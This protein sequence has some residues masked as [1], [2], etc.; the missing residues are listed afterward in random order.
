MKVINVKF[1]PG[2]A[3]LLFA[4][5]FGAVRINGLSLEDLVD[6]VQAA[7]LKKGEKS[8]RIQFGSPK[9]ILAPRHEAV[10][11]L[12]ENTRSKLGPGIMAETLQLYAKPDGAALWTASQQTAFF[13]AVAAL[14]SLEGLQYYSAS[15]SA[16]RTLYETSTVID[17]PSTK[18]AVPDPVYSYLPGEL[19]LYARQKDLT[20]GD[21]IYQ[22]DYRTSSDSLIFVQQNLTPMTV[23]IITAVG[24][25][26]LHS[27][28]AVID[29]G[30][31]LLVYAISMAKASVLP[32]IKDKIGNSFS[33]RAEAIMS[34][35]SKQ[36]DK[37]YGK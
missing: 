36:A 26:K 33:N 27:V 29:A 30:D 25:N 15:R 5:L 13:N 8:S 2:A 32:G 11:L 37:V 18:K 1:I 23:G 4:C 7:A 28:L 10:L 14:S 34:W 35:F 9:P 3:V 6:P 17:G 12:I 20:F 31:F 22:Y 21:N 16:W 24:K 19:T